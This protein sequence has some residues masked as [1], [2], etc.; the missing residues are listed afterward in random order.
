MGTLGFVG[1][2]ANCLIVCRPR[3]L[4]ATRSDKQLGPDRRDSVGVRP[5][6]VKAVEQHEAGLRAVRLGHGNGPVEPDHR[7]G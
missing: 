5:A 3:L 2:Q 1:A 4:R 6:A 7:R